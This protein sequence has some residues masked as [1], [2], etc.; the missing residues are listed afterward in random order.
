[1]GSKAVIEV[2][3]VGS[4]GHRLALLHA[5]NQCPTPDNPSSC[6]ALNASG[7]L[8]T[9]FLVPSILDQENGANS[10]FNSLQFRFET[11]SF[12]GLQL[13]GFYQ[14]AKSIDDSSSLQPQIF[15]TSPTVASLL[16]AARVD[17]PDDFAGANNISPTLSLQ[18][19]LPLIITRPNLPQD[20]SNLA[21]ERARSDFDL[22][23]RFVLNYV[24]AVPRFAPGNWLWLAACG[25]YHR[26]V[27]SAVQRVRR[28]FRAAFPSKRHRVDAGAD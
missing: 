7:Q 11:R 16:V 2:A 15:L 20:S 12:H 9:P 6:L 8:A 26:S 13:G 27:G 18:G 22:Q 3:Y 21:G 10:N 5:I 4:A 28:F 14:Y 17:N 25:H 19:N 24:Y 23:H 1:V